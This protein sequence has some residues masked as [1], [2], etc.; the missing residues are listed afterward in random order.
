MMIEKLN[1]TNPVANIQKAVKKEDSFSL[2]LHDCVTLSKDAEKFA[3]MHLAIR[4]ARISSDVRADKV[5][6]MRVKFADPSYMSSVIDGLADSIMD[7][8]GI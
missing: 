6:E 4:T 3:E 1:V 2:N 7:A 5:A 8:Y